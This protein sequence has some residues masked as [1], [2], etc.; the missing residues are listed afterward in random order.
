MS[1]RANGGFSFFSPLSSDLATILDS[2]STRQ[3][4]MPP[5]AQVY[6]AARGV[7]APLSIPIQRTSAVKPVVHFPI[8]QF[9]NFGNSAAERRVRQGARILT[10]RQDFRPG[11]FGVAKDYSGWL[12]CVTRYGGT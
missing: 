5:R 11:T 12:G 10:S 4:P 9:P 6:P 7:R 3:E 1:L 8:L 2:G